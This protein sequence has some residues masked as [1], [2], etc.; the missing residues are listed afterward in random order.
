[1]TTWIF[2]WTAKTASKTNGGF[3]EAWRLLLY[4]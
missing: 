4:F 1:M 2:F 3:M